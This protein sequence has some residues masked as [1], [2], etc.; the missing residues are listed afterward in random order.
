MEDKDFEFQ[1]IS[2]EDAISINGGCNDVPCSGHGIGRVIG[3]VIKFWANADYGR[4]P[5]A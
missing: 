5:L 2:N 3:Y 1:P 4:V